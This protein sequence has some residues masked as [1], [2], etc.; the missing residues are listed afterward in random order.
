MF[1]IRHI[2]ENLAVSDPKIHTFFKIKGSMLAPT[3]KYTW[4]QFICFT[5]TTFEWVEV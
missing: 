2:S 1:F 5:L 3:T 4:L